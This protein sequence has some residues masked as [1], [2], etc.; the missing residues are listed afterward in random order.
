MKPS[1]PAGTVVAAAISRNTLAIDG[2]TVACPAA[3][4]CGYNWLKLRDIA[5][6]LVGTDKA[7][8]LSY[9]APTK[10]IILT[11]GG[12][13]EP[14]GDELKDLPD[15]I[16]AIASP[17]KLMIDGVLVDIAAY[18]I[19]GYNYFR[20]RDLAILLDFSIESSGG[21]GPVSLD[22]DSPFRAGDSPRARL[23]RRNKR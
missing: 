6:I 5:K 3:I 18:I 2:A 21:N 15:D 7:F 4:I 11:T 16:S 1:E 12:V 13:Y 20:L 9:E 10:T 22:L 19:D 17:Q 8:S 23:Q 14:I